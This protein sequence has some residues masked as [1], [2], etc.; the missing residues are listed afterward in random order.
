MLDT[1][2]LEPLRMQHEASVER[3]GDGGEHE[4]GERVL[5]KRVQRVQRMPEYSLVRERCPC[6]LNEDLERAGGEDDESPEDR[7]VHDTGDRLTE[8]FRL[9]D[10][11]L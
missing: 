5:R 6:P 4:N 9:R 3:E 10:T 1:V 11:D 7:G 2:A 8:N